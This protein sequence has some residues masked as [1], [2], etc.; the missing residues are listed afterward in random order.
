MGRRKH[1]GFGV[2]KRSQQNSTFF[3]RDPS[4]KVFS[5]KNWAWVSFAEKIDFR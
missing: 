1:A 2:L 3:V 5:E 4:D